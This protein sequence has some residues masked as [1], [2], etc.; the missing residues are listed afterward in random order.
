[1]LRQREKA[2]IITT[3]EAHYTHGSTPVCGTQGDLATISPYMRHL[4]PFLNNRTEYTKLKKH[5]YNTHNL[6]LI[7][8]SLFV[9]RYILRVQY[10]VLPG[11]REV[12]KRVRTVF[13]HCIALLPNVCRY[14]YV[15]LL[16]PFRRLSVAS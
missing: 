8:R 16:L 3:G 12:A 2:Y 14:A 10:S 9:L 5:T 11:S 7:L 6:N 1:M 4:S 15:S 13:I